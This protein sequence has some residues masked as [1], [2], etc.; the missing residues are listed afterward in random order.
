VPTSADSLAT[1]TWVILGIGGLAA[2][3]AYPVDDE[4]NARLQS[5]EAA[6]RFFS[7]GQII[8]SAALQAG[9]AVG[10]YVIGDVREPKS[11]EMPKQPP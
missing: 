2:A 10:A 6:N 4:V 3:A 5:S 1:S 11:N 9:V 8:G 7:A